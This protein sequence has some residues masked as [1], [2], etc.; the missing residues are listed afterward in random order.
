MSRGR[1]PR[2]NEA[3]VLAAIRYLA[4]G[5]NLKSATHDL[6]IPY[7]TLRNLLLRYRKRWGYASN[8]QLVAVFAGSGKLGGCWRRHA[9]GTG[10]T[11]ARD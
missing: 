5:G 9:R 11:S 10:P 4:S 1:T 7:E 3:L 6:G 2:Q 8:Y